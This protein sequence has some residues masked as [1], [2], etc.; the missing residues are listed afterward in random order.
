M[1]AQGWT[2]MLLSVT[3]VTGTFIWCLWKILTAPKNKK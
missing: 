1:N 2:I 3:G